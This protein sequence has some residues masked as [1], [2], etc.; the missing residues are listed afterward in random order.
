[1]LS[2]FGGHRLPHSQPLSAS[3]ERNKGGFPMHSPSPQ[4]TKRPGVGP[5]RP[6]NAGTDRAD[7]TRTAL[8]RYLHPRGCPL[9]AIIIHENALCQGS[10]F[11]LRSGRGL[12]AGDVRWGKCLCCAPA[13]KGAPPHPDPL[14]VREGTPPLLLPGETGIVQR[15]VPGGEGHVPTHVISA[16]RPG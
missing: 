10:V 6:V 12:W 1:M 16:G 13:G 5:P 7:F 15:T 14:P 4:T 8:R 9:S 11:D 3:G 2:D